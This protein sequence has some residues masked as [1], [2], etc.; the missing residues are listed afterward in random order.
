MR[1]VVFERLSGRRAFYTA[2]P[3]TAPLTGRDPR[4]LAFFMIACGVGLAGW[5]GLALLQMPERTPAA[6]DALVELRLASELQHM[7]PLLAP[8]G[9]RLALLEGTIRAEVL[10][11]G[12]LARREPQQWLGVGLV[13]A[14][15]GLGSYVLSLARR[16]G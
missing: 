12:R 9:E 16:R 5:H 8:H 10:A 13:L 15:F 1:I 4:V 6:V 7:G 14:V 11:E 2:D 3:M